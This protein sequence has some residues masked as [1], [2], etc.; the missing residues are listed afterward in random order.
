MAFQ[1]KLQ[2]VGESFACEPGESVLEA[3]LRAGIALPYSCRDGTCGTCKA[4]VVEGNVV[5]TVDELPGLCPEERADGWC[6]MCQAQAQTDLT[7]EASV[8]AGAAQPIRVLPARVRGLERLAD[9]VMRVTLQL[10]R[11]EK[12]GFRAGQYLDILLGEG[13]RRSYSL[14]NPPEGDGDLELHIRHYPGGLFSDQ[15]FNRTR[16]G[17]VL[18]LRGPYG[19]FCLDEASGATRIFIAGGTGFAPVKSIIEDAHA[20][21]LDAPT[22]LYWGARRTQDIYLRDLAERWAR[23]L[24]G[25]R[26]VPVLSE[27]DAGGAG[28]ARLGFVHEAVLADFPDLST[29]DVYASGP[30]PM[31]NAI[32]TQF[33]CNGAR[34]ERIFADS[35]EFA[36]R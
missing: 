25:F 31:V 3:G 33:P 6:L 20:R 15:L 11:T 7:L 9:D 24:P 16:E 21:G 28:G 2:P 32:R 29:C 22:H 4:R 5:Y 30:P 34:A 1:I 12:L 13:R 36:R 14:A 26:F 17:Q 8:G 18:R 27:T 19:S 23:E 10:P 35:F